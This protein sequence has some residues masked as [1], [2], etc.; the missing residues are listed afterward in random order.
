MLGHPTKTAVNLSH[1]CSH[2]QGILFSETAIII[3]YY[4]YFTVTIKY[5]RN[6][7]LD[8]VWIKVWPYLP[9]ENIE[10]GL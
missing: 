6:Q 1:D 9:V 10:L 3:I 4:P 7:S 8:E 2:L 5:Q